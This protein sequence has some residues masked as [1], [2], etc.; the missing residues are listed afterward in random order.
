MMNSYSFMFIDD[1]IEEYQKKYSK[2]PKTAKPKLGRHN[3]FFDDGKEVTVTR[4][5]M[6]LSMLI[7]NYRR[8]HQL[9]QADLAKACAIIGKSCNVKMSQNDI[10]NYEICKTTPTMPKFQILMKTMHATPDMI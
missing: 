6:N 8:I 5:Q 9:S 1:R 4:K 10:S 3:T 2:Q 7:Q